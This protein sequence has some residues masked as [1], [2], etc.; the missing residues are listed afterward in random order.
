MTLYTVLKLIERYQIVE[1]TTMVKI[2]EHAASI[3][4]TSADLRYG[5][6]LSVLDLMYGLMLP[7]GNDAAIALAEYFG[8]LLLSSQQYEDD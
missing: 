1:A 8:S 3:E 7:S 2:S 4:G 5:D 6:T